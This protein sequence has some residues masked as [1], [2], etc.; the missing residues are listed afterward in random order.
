MYYHGYKIEAQYLPGD[1]FRVLKDGRVV[2]K[3]PTEVDFYRV[4]CLITGWRHANCSSTKEAKS[5]IDDT[6]AMLENL[7]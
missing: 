7:P 3:N 4:T 5:M 1:N 2:D 6:E